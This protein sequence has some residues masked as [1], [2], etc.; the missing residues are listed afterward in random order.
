M[1]SRFSGGHRIF[2]VQGGMYCAIRSLFTISVVLA[3]MNIHL[4]RTDIGMYTW[5]TER[6]RS[7]HFML[8]H[9]TV[10]CIGN[11]IYTQQ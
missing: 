3:C 6:I 4:G 7:Q 10:C 2:C 5:I 8:M 11:N 1:L 9:I